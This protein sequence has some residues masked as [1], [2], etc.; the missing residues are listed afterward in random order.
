MCANQ[1]QC[2]LRGHLPFSPLP[3]V[4]LPSLVW[5]PPTCAHSVPSLPHMRSL[6]HPSRIKRKQDAQRNAV[7]N[8]KR[9]QKGLSPPARASLHEQHIGP[10]ASHG[11]RRNISGSDVGGGR[12]SRGCHCQPRRAAQH[13]HQRRRWHTHQTVCRA[14]ATASHGKL[15]DVSVSGVV[16]IGLHRAVCR[17]AAAASRGELC[18]AAFRLLQVSC[19]CLLARCISQLPMGAAPQSTAGF[20]HC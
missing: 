5:R 20:A 16:G 15:H 19:R 11:E 1:I 12:M 10:S 13:Q 6:S 4:L 7:R 17:A 2:V 14:A 8:V 3:G 9:S 18:Q